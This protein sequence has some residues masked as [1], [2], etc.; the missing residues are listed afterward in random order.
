MEQRRYSTITVMIEGAIS[1]G[2]V[3]LPFFGAAFFIHKNR[4]LGGS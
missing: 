3:K 4:G 2:I 1:T